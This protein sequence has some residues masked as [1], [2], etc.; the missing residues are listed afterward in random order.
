MKHLL[1]NNNSKKERDNHVVYQLNC[2]QT[3]CNSISYIGYTRTSL[4]QRMQSHVYK[5]AIKDHIINT[6]KSKPTADLLVDS[7]KILG[8]I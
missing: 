6:H 2:T 4:R 3:E 1:L 8:G 7:C 5:G